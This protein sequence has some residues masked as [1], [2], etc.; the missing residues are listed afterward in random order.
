MVNRTSRGNTPTRSAIGAASPFVLVLALAGAGCSSSTPSAET[1][2]DESPP[3]GPVAPP[4]TAADTAEPEAPDASD[5][6]ARDG[7]CEDC[8]ADA[9]CADDP[10]PTTEP[11]SGEPVIPDDPHDDPKDDP[12][13]D[14]KDDPTEI[15][16]PGS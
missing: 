16:P 8:G 5:L 11:S 12:A 2:Q 14:P 3:T 13:D 1:P 7:P 4:P 15:A 6:A 10:T 9:A